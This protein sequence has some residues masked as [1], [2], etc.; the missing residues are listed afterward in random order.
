MT[1]AAKPSGKAAE[2]LDAHVA[3]TIDRLT[4]EHLQAD[5][6]RRVDALLATA[7]KLKLG[8]VVTVKAVEQ[9][10]IGYA[11]DMQI[12]GAIPALV[13]D[14]ARALYE[15]PV[16]EKTRLDALVPDKVFH[17]VLDKFIEMDELR[18]SLVHAAVSNPIFAALVTDLLY[19]GLR[20]YMASGSK[21]A[22]KVPGARS[23][24]KLGKGFLDRA[25]PELGSSLEDSIKTYVNRNTQASMAASERHLQRAL[26][27]D[28]FRNVMSQ[29]WD[30][31][32]HLTV[33]DLRGFAGELDIEELFVIGYEYW[34]HLRNTPLYKE[35]I[36]SGIRVF[37]DTYRKTTLADLLAEIGVTRD[38]VVADAMRF[39]PKALGG[40]HKKG[41]LEP[42][43]HDELAGFYASDAAAR[44]LGD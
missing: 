2:L 30:D 39:A 5:V 31:N 4:G 26:A 41:L 32:K 43:V 21:L 40:L 20:D 37:F 27:S 22:E 15:H 1:E 17:E 14:I 24:M 3:W 13:G 19:S 29:A 7:A 35:L 16:H 18:E 38:M 33:A 23:A 28:E 8:D 34:Q 9:T 10:A 6:E 36:G 11:S 42:L 12:G 25:R 44:V